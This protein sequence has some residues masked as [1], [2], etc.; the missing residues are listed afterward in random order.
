MIA[1]NPS[2]AARSHTHTHLCMSPCPSSAPSSSS[3]G[4]FPGRSAAP[5]PSP[6]ARAPR[7]IGPVRSTSS[8]AGTGA[9]GS[10]TERT[11]REGRWFDGRGCSMPPR[12]PTR[13]DSAKLGDGEINL[14]SASSSPRALDAQTVIWGSPS[15]LRANADHL[16]LFCARPRIPPSSAL[17]ADTHRFRLCVHVCVCVCTRAPLCFPLFYVASPSVPRRLCPPF[18]D[19]GRNRDPQGPA[20]PKFSSTAA[21]TP[22]ARPPASSLPPDQRHAA[23][24]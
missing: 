11:R 10:G 22:L 1:Y 18:S 9:P 16:P 13:N 17:H 7:T 24:T 5:T 19:S 2:R 4:S 6:P 12:L 23:P 20:P 8:S 14:K 3:S 15:L 21:R